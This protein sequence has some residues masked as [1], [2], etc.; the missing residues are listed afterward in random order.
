MNGASW[1]VCLCHIEGGRRER[2][3]EKEDKRGRWRKGEKEGDFTLTTDRKSC[4]SRS[5]TV[6]M[7]AEV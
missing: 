6:H 7:R 4:A 5:L 2:R 3:R 1:D